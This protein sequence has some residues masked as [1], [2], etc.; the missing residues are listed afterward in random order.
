M[1]NITYCSRTSCVHIDCS[2]H[3]DNAPKNIDI[4][5]ADLSDGWCFDECDSDECRA[6]LLNAICAGTQHTSHWCDDVCRSMCGNDGTCAF[7]AT[8]ADAIENEFGKDF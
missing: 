2:R 1:S 4:S 3:Q 6:R 8:I 5:I 7:C